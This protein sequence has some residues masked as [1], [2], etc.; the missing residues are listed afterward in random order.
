MAAAAPTFFLDSIRL[1]LEST[2]LCW[3]ASSEVLSKEDAILLYDEHYASLFHLS[4]LDP[5]SRGRVFFLV[6]FLPFPENISLL[7]R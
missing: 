7:A 3:L 6:F 5:D 1:F 2:S 4:E